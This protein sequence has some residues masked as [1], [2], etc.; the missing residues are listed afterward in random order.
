MALPLSVRGT[1]GAAPARGGRRGS[2]MTS[3]RVAQILSDVVSPAPGRRTLPQRLVDACAAALPVTGVGMVIMNQDGPAGVAAATDGPA[4]V[5][6]GL[7]FTLGEGPCVDSSKS[8]RPILLPDLAAAGPARWPAFCEGALDAGIA[9]IFAL[10]LR[11]G[12]VRMGVLD[13]YRDTSG[14]LSSDELA[15]AL[16]FA[17]AATTILLHLQFSQEPDETG[18]AHIPLLNDRAEI[19][20]AAGYMAGH[21]GMSVANA[22][23]LLRGRAFS[24]DSSITALAVEVMAGRQTFTVDE[25]GIAW[26]LPG[27]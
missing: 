5:M 10:P 12:S 20:Q 7:Q 3:V 17:D 23:V 21:T 4:A 2:T 18:L 1:G 25:T 26:D 9:A 24:T 22:L 6:E 16:S 13:L 15:E 14:P 8:G 27:P 19:H 11:V